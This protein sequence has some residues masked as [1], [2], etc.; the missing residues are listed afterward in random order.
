MRRTL[1]GLVAAGAVV[2]AGGC[3]D[4]DDDSASSDSGGGSGEFCD[5]FEQL[6]ADASSEDSDPD[7]ARETLENL[8]PPS[9]IEAE[10]NQ[11]LPVVLRAEDVDTSDP[12]AVAQ[13][14]AEQ[15][16]AAPAGQAV[17]QYL[18]EDCGIESETT[19]AE[20]ADTGGGTGGGGVDPG[21]GGGG[22]EPPAPG[23][24]VPGGEA[25]APGGQPGQ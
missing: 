5:T 23:A 1:I 20:G 11:Y 10:W 15:S 3:S 8:E 12:E 7:A 4:A 19:G 16:E 24:E 14:Q 2:V 6:V 13:F 21:A 18:A 25:P 22:G 9:E 17:N